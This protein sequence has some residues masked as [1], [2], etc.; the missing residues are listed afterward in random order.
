MCFQCFQESFFPEPKTKKNLRKEKKNLF[1][2]TMNHKSGS[3]MR[4]QLNLVTE[5][6]K[7]DVKQVMLMK[8]YTCD[9]ENFLKERDVVRN[10]EISFSRDLREA[11]SETLDET[12][13]EVDTLIIKFHSLVHSLVKGE[14]KVCRE[15]SSNSLSESLDT[16]RGAFSKK[17][18][19]ELSSTGE[20][21]RSRK[22]RNIELERAH[23]IKMNNLYES[24]SETFRVSVEKNASKLK[25]LYDGET[26]SIYIRGTSD[27]ER[28]REE[29]RKHEHT[30]RVKTLQDSEKRH[31][32]SV[33][34]AEQRVLVVIRDIEKNARAQEETIV[35]S[36]FSRLLDQV[37]R[38][39]REDILIEESAYYKYL[40]CVSSTTQCVSVMKKCDSILERLFAHVR[41]SVLA[42]LES[43]D[44]A[45]IARLRQTCEEY[46]HTQLG[47]IPMDLVQSEQNLASHAK[48]Y[49]SRMIS[50]LTGI[51]EEVR[52]AFE[53]RARRLG[54]VYGASAEK[55]FRSQLETRTEEELRVWTSKRLDNMSKLAVQHNEKYVRHAINVVRRRIS[56]HVREFRQRSEE[57]GRVL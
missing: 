42:E 35:I 27:L 56:K 4:D 50:K 51:V 23:T 16:V 45:E 30:A 5:T 1:T 37:I 48:V 33:R 39:K 9:R 19:R 44:C 29:Y 2:H 46:V 26:A 47:N 3:P 15:T 54:L 32:E 11:M 49:S 24:L 25:D 12:S 52:D 31:I 28:K 53:D 34:L 40:I 43:H 57:V 22:K 14:S 18:E 13:K 38:E 41:K 21:L 20:R 36:H 55:L 10:A 6:I 7:E 8:M 17:T